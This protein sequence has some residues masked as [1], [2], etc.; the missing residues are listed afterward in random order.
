MEIAN[1]LKNI[2]NE[3][4]RLS[5]HQGVVTATTTGS[6]TV[7][8]SGGT[9]SI[10]GVKYLESYVPTVNDVVS[11]VVNNS[12][13]FILGKLSTVIYPAFLASS[14]S[15][16]HTT[17]VG[18]ILDFNVAR[19]NRGSAFSTSTYKFTAPIAGIYA[20]DFIVYTQNGAAI[21]SIA[22]R[23]N[24]TELVS[25]DT[26]ISYQSA[27]TIG[28]FTLSGNNLLELAVNDT[29]DVAVRSAASANL[30]WYGGHSRF[31]GYFVMP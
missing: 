10:S 3:N 19:L 29:V 9:D 27:T 28:D 20:F 6:V 13:L 5:F 31:S 23:K 16:T 24:G 25:T 14:S 2:I 21:K 26:D 12:D 4:T 15:G 7:T 8:L 22:W 11:I 17:N 30:Q 1:A 18:T